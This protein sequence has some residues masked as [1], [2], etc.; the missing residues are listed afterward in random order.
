MHKSPPKGE[1]CE[2][3]EPC[4]VD[5][6]Y[7]K[8]TG[9]KCGI[10]KLAYHNTIIEKAE[11]IAKSCALK[12]GQHANQLGQDALSLSGCPTQGYG[13]NIK[14]VL[15]ANGDMQPM[16]Y[17][18]WANNKKV[19]SGLEKEAH[20][21]KT[22]N[23]EPMGTN[24]VRGKYGVNISMY[25]DEAEFVT[26]KDIPLDKN[27]VKI[28]Y[29]VPWKIER[30]SFNSRCDGCIPS[31]ANVDDRPIS[32]LLEQI[33]RANAVANKLGVPFEVKSCFTAMKAGWGN[34]FIPL[35]KENLEK[36]RNGIRPEIVQGPIPEDCLC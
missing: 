29:W 34:Q 33:E 12:G 30:Y 23:G 14:F 27:L 36:L 21:V 2:P 24:R 20:D 18:E 9:K 32:A 25:E 10:G 17:Y 3:I 11:E 13:G 19:D 28:E 1:F 7:G 26:Q 5:T 8:I 16:C 15:K 31:Y 22:P 35:N 4:E 6:P